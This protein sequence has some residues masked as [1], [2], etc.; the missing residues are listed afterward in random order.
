MPAYI[1]PHKQASVTKPYV[2]P[3]TEQQTLAK[4]ELPARQGQNNSYTIEQIR[5]Q[6][7]S[8]V[9]QHTLNGKDNL[10]YIL[11]HYNQ[12]PQWPPKIC[13][14]SNLHLLPSTSAGSDAAVST[15]G[16]A[17]A[18]STNA[19]N[20]SD[21]PSR[22]IAVFTQK[23]GKGTPF[24]F[25]GMYSVVNIDYLESDTDE[26]VKML[27]FKWGVET[28]RARSGWEE[29]LSTRWA[30]VELHKDATTFDPMASL[31]R[32]QKGV[33]EVLNEM[34]LKA[35]KKKL[36][37][38]RL[39]DSDIKEE[40]GAKRVTDEDGEHSKLGEHRRTLNEGSD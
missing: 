28:T 7:G 1:P 34:R 12:N 39:E 18:P 27:E 24:G 30:V 8:L 33:T 20:A 15:K 4:D 31:R 26:L 36:S 37:E 14:H 5:H 29:S 17:S 35:T 3:H 38:K 22:L 25:I 10:S 11:L 9:K 40:T 16:S 6:F 19:I 23:P 2:P 32:P 21:N 13:C